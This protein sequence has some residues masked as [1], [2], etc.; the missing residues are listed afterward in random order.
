M[1]NHARLFGGAENLN[2]FAAEISPTLVA[3]L[4]S[5]L[6]VK[7]CGGKTSLNHGALGG[8]HAPVAQQFCLGLQQIIAHKLIGC[9]PI[10]HNP[11]PYFLGRGLARSGLLGLHSSAESGFVYRLAL[12]AAD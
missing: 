6:R 2:A 8:L 9:S 1:Q 11:V 3:Y 12:L 7:G 4:T 10:E 5:T